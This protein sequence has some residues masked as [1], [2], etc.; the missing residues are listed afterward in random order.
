MY[1]LPT[2]VGLKEK[3][4]SLSQKYQIVI[5]IYTIWLL[6]WVCVLIGNS[7]E[8]HFAKNYVLPFF[9]STILFPFIIVS[10]IYIYKLR[11]SKNIAN[12][13]TASVSDVKNTEE[14][15]SN[16]KKVIT[17][18]SILSGRETKKEMQYDTFSY[19]W[20]FNEFLTI[21]GSHIEKVWHKNSRTN[22]SNNERTK[23][24]R[25]R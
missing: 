2:K 7:N 4:T 20:K 24:K 10:S 16:L 9:L 17:K 23:N 5:I 13:N 15:H 25:K 12:T 21:N 22:K 8:R 19:V 11:K 3:F 1:R 14:V 18:K 6:G